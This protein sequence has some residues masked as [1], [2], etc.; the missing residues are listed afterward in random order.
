MKSTTIRTVT[1]LAFGAAAFVATLGCPAVARAETFPSRAITMIVPFPAGG[2]TDT[3]ARILSERMRESLGQAVIVENVTGA[4]ASIGD[5]RAAQATPDGYTL[6]LGNWTSHVG[7]GAMYPAAH[8]AMEH[9]QPIS[10]L[11][12]TPLMIVGRN[13]LPAKDA[14]ELIAWLKANPNKASIANIGAGSGAHICWLYFADKTGTS[15]T[16]V[17]YR[18]GAPVMADLIAGQIDLFCAE[19]SQTLSFLRAGKIKAYAVMSKERWPAAPDVPTMDEVGVKGMYISFWN[20]M[21]TTK[22]TPK[23][24]VAK[25]DAAIQDALADATVRKRLTDIGHVIAP[26]EDQTPEALAAFHKAEMDKWWPIIK[27]ANIKVE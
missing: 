17:P 24:V 23:D 26:R 2:P 27:A 25:L 12:A 7:A 19:A 13:T 18:G 4:G 21:C 9:M 20:G 6:I 1:G 3:L 8:D 22:G 14:K 11:S 16:L 10:E 15:G 5:A